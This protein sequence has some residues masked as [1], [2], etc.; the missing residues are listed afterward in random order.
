MLD[1]VLGREDTDVARLLELL[2]KLLDK[3]ESNT[4]QYKEVVQKLQNTIRRMIEE[5]PYSQMTVIGQTGMFKASHFNNLD[6]DDKQVLKKNDALKEDA[7]KSIDLV[8]LL[9]Q[10]PKL[11]YELRDQYKSSTI[12]FKFVAF[13]TANVWN[14][15]IQM[16]KRVF[17][18]TKFYMFRQT[19]TEQVMLMLPKSVARNLEYQ[20][21]L[22]A[23][24]AGGSNLLK[25]R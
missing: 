23:R 6:E 10:K 11:D 3:T 15:S 13:K 12:T 18:T 16:P 17:F 2:Q 19:Q 7:S 1:L 14:Q 4:D 20:Q 9:Q 24:E 25:G 21:V 22:H 5:D 8:K